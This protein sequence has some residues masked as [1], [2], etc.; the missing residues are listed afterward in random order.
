MTE[1][2]L[3]LFQAVIDTLGE[4]TVKGYDNMSKLIGS[5]NA[6]QEIIQRNTKED[7]DG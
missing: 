4:I 7:K 5:I 2:D 6:I 3:L 1:K